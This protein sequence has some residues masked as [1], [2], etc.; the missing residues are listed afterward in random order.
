MNTPVLSIEHLSVA[1]PAGADRS[2]AL[3]DISLQLQAGQTLCVVGESGSGKSVLATTVMGLLAAELKVTQGSVALQGEDLLSASPARLRAL[4]GQAMGMVF[5]E[6]MTALNPVMRCGEQVDEVLRTHTDWP[7]ATRRDHILKMMAQV[8]L[9]DPERIWAS[10]P[11][12]LSGGQRQRIVIAMAMIMKPALL[13]CDEP[14]TALDVTTQ[15]EILQLI[16]QL[17]QDT[18]SA[19]LFITHDMGVVA[20]IADQV[21]VMHQGVAVDMGTRDDVLLRPQADYT[22]ALLAAVP[23]MTPPAARVLADTPPVLQAQAVCKTYGTHLALQDAGLRLRAGETVGIVGESGSGKSTL[24]RCILRLIDPTSGDIHWGEDNIA[25]WP[26]RRLRVV[27]HRVQVVFQDPNRS[28]NP[29]LTIGQSMVEG[30]RNFGAS[31][32]EAERIGQ[33]LLQQMRLPEGA[34]QRYPSQ[35]SGGQRQRIALARALAC[36]PD[37]LVADE[38]VSALDVSVQAQI[39]DLLREV[40]ARMGLGLLFIT[41]DLRVAAQLCDHVI[42]M[43]QG[44]IVERGATAELYAQPQHAYTR[45][46]LDSAPDLQKP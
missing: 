1:L 24:A 29:R 22:R 25:T 3:Q 9:P 30:A 33:E 44:R 32:L 41:H 43:Q 28:L 26:E 8:R 18:G 17:Q 38:A 42:V 36:R 45:A 19:V 20:D 11:H 46:L 34:W 16:H 40:Q 5:Q 7:A 4:R 39:L 14:T 31:V 23:S 21:L 13:I 37:V 35:F 12:Q 2:H 27:R 10:Y 15:Q 6:P